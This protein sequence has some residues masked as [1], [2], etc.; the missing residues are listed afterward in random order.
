MPRPSP[1]SGVTPMWLIATALWLL[2]VG[3][4][5]WLNLRLGTEHTICLLKNLT[6]IP[7]PGCG[8][9]RAVLA[10]AGGRIFEAL[11]F[12]PLSTLLLLFSPFLL[13]AWHHNRKLPPAN[14]WHPGRVFWFI[15]LAL[16]LANWCF[17]LQTLG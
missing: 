12:N 17:V 10:L 11:S 1:T 13:F 3:A 2:G 7:C 15:T 8:G 14:R 9:T 6:N 5:T 4:F 16:V